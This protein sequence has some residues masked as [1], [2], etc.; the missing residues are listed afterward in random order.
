MDFLTKELGQT[1]VSADTKGSLAADPASSPAFNYQ[2][3]L[4]LLS[5]I[6]KIRPQTFEKLQN[7]L[8]SL[9][10]CLQEYTADDAAA[11]NASLNAN[12]DKSYQRL[13]LALINK[14][15]NL[16]DLTARAFSSAQNP[17]GA[18]DAAYAFEKSFDNL[19]KAF[20]EGTACGNALAK[21]F[22]E[23]LSE[24]ADRH[25][26]G[27]GL[28]RD[29]ASRNVSFDGKLSKENQ[30]GARK[31][32]NAAAS[33]VKDN[34]Q[35][36]LNSLPAD[37]SSQN[38]PSLKE[39]N[40]EYTQSV[41]DKQNADYGE[42][43]KQQ[44]RENA[45]SEQ[46]AEADRPVSDETAQRIRCII[47]RAAAAARRGNLYPDAQPQEGTVTEQNV[48]N[49]TNTTGVA[50]D[51]SENN[52]GNEVSLS[53]LA[54]RAS[55][56]QQQF[57]E[58]RRKL[59]EEGKL[60]DPAA[61]PDDAE[62]KLLKPND[63]QKTNENAADLIK[64]AVKAD[65]KAAAVKNDLQ[66]A[67]NKIG[68]LSNLLNTA[69][70]KRS[71]VKTPLSTQAVRDAAASVKTENLHTDAALKENVRLQG[72]NLNK[73]DT[74]AQNVNAQNTAAKSTETAV[75][76]AKPLPSAAAFVKRGGNMPIPEQSKPE[77]SGVVKD[78]GLFSKLAALFTKSAPEPAVNN[79]KANL[80]TPEISAGNAMM[81]ANPLD[82]FMK[83][84]S[85][86]AQ[87]PVL[88]KELR[89]EAEE[90]SSKL[91]DPISDLTS[92]NGW[93]SFVQ[94]PMS[95]DSTRAVA[96][97]QWAFLL[98]C[99]RYKQLGKSVNNLLKKSKAG[100]LNLDDALD[101]MLLNHPDSK[102][103]IEN[104][105]QET[106]NQIARLQNKPGDNNNPLLMRY[107]P[108]PPA[109][110]GGREGSLFI[111]KEQ[112]PKQKAVW[113]LSF[114]FDLKDLGW[115]EIKAAACLPEV[116]LSFAAEKLQGLKAVQ[117]HVNDLTASLAK[118]GLEPSASAP[119]LGSLNMLPSKE[120]K[121]ITTEQP[122]EPATGIS[123][124]I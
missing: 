90:L 35:K 53:E 3:S 80:I 24:L 111:N 50:E 2:A 86:A 5:E 29:L 78:G 107:L 57:R 124:Q 51:A 122:K 70:L 40:P 105:S 96:L 22:T 98:L 62:T 106:L 26:M 114:N 13:S 41:P 42:M 43:L 115:V 103:D 23:S 27:V 12:G 21:T 32:L 54:A 46:S 49:A 85:L 64:N 73:Q 77:L 47:A 120:D 36:V 58:D 6:A 44:R 25:H 17:V 7:D 66:T 48:K 4:Q 38:T 37:D 52:Q 75:E 123:V 91:L 71:E 55:K 110:E 74:G 104:L 83:A 121:E 8:N 56:L 28:K 65:P 109:Y 61:Y 39:K 79:V 88:P 119:R 18:K 67:E 34:A 11:S 1:T 97:Q 60:P 45:R 102:D 68:D 20:D 108:L 94:G 81:R 117:D 93:L 72:E 112:H 59:A 95:P 101:D 30:E 84:L 89:K 33:F 15:K 100:D 92:A 118:L 87:N 14:D 99:L 63:L 10:A 31:V 82:H 16:A 69:L 9:H 19:P 76:F 116:K 113:H